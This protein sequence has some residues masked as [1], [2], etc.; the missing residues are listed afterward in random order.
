MLSFLFTALYTLALLG[1]SLYGIQ[2]LVL[3]VLFL[4]QRRKH[5]APVLP[6]PKNWPEVTVQLPVYNEQFVIERLIDAAC[7]L[8]YPAEALSI[9]VL[10]DST[11][12]TTNLARQRVDYHRQRGVNIQLLH[13]KDR[14]GFKAGALA[15]GLRKASGEFIAIFDADFVP[16]RD[17]LRRLVP[18]LVADP[19]VGM[20][21]AR[22]GHLNDSYSLLTRSQA[23]FL[24]GHFIIE[25]TT[26]SRTGMLFN[27][28]GS[29]GIWRRACIED[30]GGWQGDTLSEDL[31]LSYRAQ[32]K[33]WRFAFAP[34]VVAPAEI[35]PQVAALKQQQYRWARGSIQVLVKLGGDILRSPLSLFQR[36]LGILHL[37]AYIAHP[38]LMVMLLACLPLVLVHGK[39]VPSMKWLS[40]VAL[41]PPLSYALSQWAIYPDWKRRIMFFPVLMSL[42]VGIAF[43]N[44][45]AVL[46]ALSR[47]PAQFVRTPKF[48][49]ETSN[50]GWS[51][52]SYSLPVEWTVWV[53]LFLTIYALVTAVIASRN[54]PPLTPMLVLFTLG[55]GYVSLLG[56]WQGRKPH[57]RQIFQEQ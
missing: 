21:Q 37:S 34:D 52:K 4:I 6:E 53:E 54:F 36:L 33:G 43:N 8:D 7:A 49:L 17:F 14:Q 31:D 42:G 20:A 44:T 45:R 25:Q 12:H 46:A 28:N 3:A 47:K 22:W 15:A 30:A 57:T 39:G 38:L 13:R 35:P 11:D 40:L 27:F 32:M 23:M 18:Y 55:F 16:P 5:A 24:D 48:H 2:S 56:L 1:L 26:R 29:A 9:Q 50:D 41:G 19:K 10:D 51:G